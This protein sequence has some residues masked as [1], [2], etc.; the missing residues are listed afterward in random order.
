MNKK[1]LIKSVAKKSGLKQRDTENVID[2]L[3]DTITSEL[4]KGNTI[5]CVGFGSFMVRKR[6]ERKGRNP[7]TGETITIAKS[8]YPAFKPGKVMVNA[9]KGK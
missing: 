7:Q 9:V 3:F 8:K 5:K 4:G 6:A 1:E 2:A